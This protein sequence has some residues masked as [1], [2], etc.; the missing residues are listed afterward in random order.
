[1]VAE[2]DAETDGAS[3]PRFGKTNFVREMTDEGAASENLGVVGAVV[4]D[5]AAVLSLL[6]VSPLLSLLSLVFG[7]MGKAT[8]T[9]IIPTLLS[10]PVS[11]S[12]IEMEREKPS[13]F[14][15]C[16]CGCVGCVGWPFVC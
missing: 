15:C 7:E 4:V 10:L 11:V 14:D 12:V 16:C 9:G 2:A 13:L 8:A 3:V 1:M 5:V 6:F